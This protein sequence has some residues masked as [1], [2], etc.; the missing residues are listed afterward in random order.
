MELSPGIAA[1]S[2]SHG[3]RNL[4]AGSDAVP[5]GAGVE[6]LPRSLQQRAVSARLI[7]NRPGVDGS[8]AEVGVLQG[9]QTCSERTPPRPPF[10]HGSREPAHTPRGIP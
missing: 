5:G 1:A 7:Q 9:Q 4:L 8:R 10:S 3:S 2:G 6:L